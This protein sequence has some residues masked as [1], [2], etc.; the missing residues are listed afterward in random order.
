MEEITVVVRNI[1]EL[2]DIV[3]NARQD[4]FD[5]ELNQM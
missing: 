4:Q 2:K 5:F 3:H 1:L